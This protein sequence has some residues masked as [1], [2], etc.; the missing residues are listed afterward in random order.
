[1]RI[2]FMLGGGVAALGVLLAASAA[3]AAPAVATDSA[4][5]RS[6]PG[7]GFGRVSRLFAGEEVDVTECRQGWCF[8]KHDGTDGWVSA[9]LLSSPDDFGNQDNLPPPRPGRPVPPP[10]PGVNFGFSIGPN[11]PDV[12]IGVDR[13]QPGRPDRGGGRRGGGGRGD[14]GGRGPEVCFYRDVNF[15]GPSFCTGPGDSASSLPGRWNDAISSIEVRGGASVD[16]Y[17]DVNFEG[18]SFTVER[19]TGQLGSLNDMISSYEVH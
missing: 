7:Q 16:I 15:E 13:N 10:P 5:V 14:G 6:G 17:E 11:G 4:S 12:Q 18:G 2:K 3:L 8:V 9:S 19:D 1:M